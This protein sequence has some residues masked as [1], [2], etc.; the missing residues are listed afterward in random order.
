VDTRT[1][2]LI[3]EA[4]ERLMQGRTTFIIAQRLTTVQKADQ[5][6]VIDNGAIAERGTHAELLARGGRYAE[7]YRLQLQDQE[8]LRRELLD[9][10][11]LV[12]AKGR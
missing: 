11:N 3:Q 4:L 6:L 1:E 8:R 7:I 2:F 12:Q 9:M 5:I 10:D